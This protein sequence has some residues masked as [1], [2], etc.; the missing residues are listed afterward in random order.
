MELKVGSNSSKGGKRV[1][2][3]SHNGA[4]SGLVFRHSKAMDG[5]GREEA[6]RH[7]VRDEMAE[8]DLIGLEASDVGKTRLSWGLLGKAV[9]DAG[10]QGGDVGLEVAEDEALPGMSTREMGVEDD[11]DG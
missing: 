2:V 11:V 9:G 4:N 8:A 7:G 1:N 10:H 3:L 6:R 5:D